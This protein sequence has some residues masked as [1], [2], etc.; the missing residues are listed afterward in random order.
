[1]VT[2]REIERVIKNARIV[3]QHMEIRSKTLPEG[4]AMAQNVQWILEQSPGAK[5]VLW[6]H[7]GQ[8]AAPRFGSGS[9][10]VSLRKML[11]GQM[12]VFGFFN[13]GSLQATL[14]AAGD[15]SVRY[16]PESP[17]PNSIRKCAE[18]FDALFFVEKTTAASA[19]Q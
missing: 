4:S 9:M 17:R 8:A 11:G 2:D 6:D 19:R 7:N 10:G 15:P 18:S 12:V 13:Q 16:R 5:M 3:I 1:M 14:A